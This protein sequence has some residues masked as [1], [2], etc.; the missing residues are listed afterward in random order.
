MS[1]IILFLS[2][3]FT[4]WIVFSI[5]IVILEIH[6]DGVLWPDWASCIAI[7]PIF[8]VLLLIRY[9]RNKIKKSK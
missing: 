1:D 4:M 9:I 6:T 3:V 5:Y 8:P 7:L 2:G